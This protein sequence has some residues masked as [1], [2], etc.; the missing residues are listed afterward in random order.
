MFKPLQTL[1]RCFW[2]AALA[3]DGF[4]TLH[5]SL[6]RPTLL[7]GLS[8]CSNTS[9]SAQ[10]HAENSLCFPPLCPLSL[11]QLALQ[12]SYI[13]PQLPYLGTTCYHIFGDVSSDA[14]R[15]CRIPAASALSEE[16]KERMSPAP[17]AALFTTYPTETVSAS[18]KWVGCSCT[19]PY[20]DSIAS[21]F[22]EFNSACL[23]KF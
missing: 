3:L 16:H 4:L 11:L 2:E 23:T 13:I 5:L 21:L 14:A 17:L 12:F 19:L 18:R 15:L 7:V 6:D 10:R 22:A 8:S 1:L 9:L 20:L